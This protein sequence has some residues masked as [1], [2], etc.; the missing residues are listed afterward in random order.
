MGKLPAKQLSLWSKISSGIFFLVGFCLLALNK[1][2]IGVT[3]LILAS[4][5]LGSLFITVDVSIW[6]E[7]KW[8]TKGDIP[9]RDERNG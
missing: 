8:G 4:L 1:I 9:F 2:S 6:F 3:D 5:F 7:K